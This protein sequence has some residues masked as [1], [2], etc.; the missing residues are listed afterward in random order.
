MEHYDLSHQDETQ[1]IEAKKQNMIKLLG[2]IKILQLL[3]QFIYFILILTREEYL[4]GL[5]FSW[6]LSGIQK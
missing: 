2:K 3:T 4:P 6:K 1:H 5:I